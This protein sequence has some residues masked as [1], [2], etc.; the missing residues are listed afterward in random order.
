MSRKGG[1]RRPKRPATSDLD[2]KQSLEMSAAMLG[3]LQ[4]FTS[5]EPETIKN[6]YGQRNFTKRY[7]PGL[8]TSAGCALLAR[9]RDTNVAGQ[10]CIRFT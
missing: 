6:I 3:E 10:P 1:K 7:R 8:L 9:V 5:R 2:V 4:H